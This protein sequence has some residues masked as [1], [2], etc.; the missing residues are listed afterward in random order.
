MI[1][2]VTIGSFRSIVDLEIELGRVNVLIGANGSGKTNILEA[3]GVLGAA[4]MGTV[5]AEALERRGVRLG[6]PARYVPAF[7]EVEAPQHVAVGAQWGIG[8]D[9]GTYRVELANPVDDPKPR[10][11]YRAEVLHSNTVELDR[12][13]V[14]NGK[15][16]PEAGLAAS[17]LAEL[18]PRTRAARLLYRLRD[19][20][21]YTPVTPYLRGTANDPQ[22]RDA[23]GLSGGRLAEALLKH[24]VGTM[25]AR[26]SSGQ[27]TYLGVVFREA[28]TQLVDWVGSGYQIVRPDE[29]A[30]APGVASGAWVL[31]LRD[32]YMAEGEDTISAYE[33]SEGALYVAFAAV[34]AAHPEVPSLLAVDDFDH[35][36]NPRLARALMERFC[37]WVI[38]NPAG[39]QVLITTHNPLILD[40][41]DLTNDQI[42]LFAVDRTVKGRTTARRVVIDRDLM[43]KSEG[44]WPLSQ[45]WVRGEIGGMP[46]VL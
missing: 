3:I 44:K 12:S 38:N 17:R 41:L 33:A 14:A 19:Y 40:G 43:E 15:L 9:C 23:V 10:W 39:R 46:R 35:A 34:I 16:N 1:T 11:S 27:E 7:R 6:L 30:L 42:R 4:A 2:K 5:D 32:R 13:R 21:I 31:V 28:M 37:G 22:Q 20:G 24:R 29:A 25:A 8:S 45:L 36:L 18:N 26:Q